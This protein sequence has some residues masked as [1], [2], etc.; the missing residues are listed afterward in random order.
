MGGEAPGSVRVHFVSQDAETQSETNEKTN[1]FLMVFTQTINPSLGGRGES[2]TFGSDFFR[3][4]QVVFVSPV[5]ICWDSLR[6][7]V[8]NADSWA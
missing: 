2:P 3:V 7:L 6:G 5:I 8:E 4:F 1:V